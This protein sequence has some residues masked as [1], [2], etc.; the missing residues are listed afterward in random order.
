MRIVALTLCSAACAVVAAVTAA[1]PALAEQ[2]HSATTTIR[3]SPRA[4]APGA[5]VEVWAFGCPDR[6]ATASSPVFVD[7]AELTPE[8]DALFSEATIRST[9][10]KGAHRVT[11]DCADGGLV[12]A[13]GTGADSAGGDGQG[14]AGGVALAVERPPS[15]VA[16]VR[17]GGGGTAP[18]EARPRDDIGAAEAYG[19]VLSGGTAVAVGGLAVHRRRHPSR[20]AS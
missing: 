10:A 19:L 14:G 15:P 18:D 5:E 4:L 3:I 20:A 7:D 12:R 1:A 17:A 9:A 11:L 6:V 16:P 2:R 8:G 13:D